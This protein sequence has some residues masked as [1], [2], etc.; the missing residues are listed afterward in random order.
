MPVTGRKTKPSTLRVHYSV[1][2]IEEYE[3]DELRETVAQKDLAELFDARD[4]GYAKWDGT[5]G[6]PDDFR[7][8]YY[9]FSLR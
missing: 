4:V 6:Q 8:G 3:Y 9:L 1:S 7:H 5:T 2:Y